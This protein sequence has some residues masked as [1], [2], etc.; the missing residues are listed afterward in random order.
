MKLIRYE[1]PS[2]DWS[3]DLDRWFDR[4]LGN[5]WGWPAMPMTPFEKL[6][7]PQLPVDT[8]DDDNNFYLRF[9]LPGVNKKEINLEV[10]NAVLT[11]SGQRRQKEK[12]SERSFSF[13]RSVSIPEGV[14]TE[15]IKAKMEDGILTVTLQKQEKRKPKAISIS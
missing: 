9:E 7:Q 10:E 1:H 13:S 4:A 2:T 15:A 8:F 6:R 5:D 3:F 12:E 14:N 11:I